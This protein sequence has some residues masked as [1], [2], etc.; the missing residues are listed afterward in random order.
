[1]CCKSVH[2]RHEFASGLKESEDEVTFEADKYKT[3]Q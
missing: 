1:M 2:K 3:T